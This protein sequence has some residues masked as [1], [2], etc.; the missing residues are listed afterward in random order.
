[1]NTITATLMTYGTDL[2]EMLAGL[3]ALAT[4]V[5]SVAQAAGEASQ[6]AQEL[7]EAKGPVCKVATHQP[8]SATFPQV[9]RVF[10]GL[11]RNS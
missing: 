8:P 2:G 10:R 7:G 6:E 5:S 1:M 11:L 4:P 3:A 9:V